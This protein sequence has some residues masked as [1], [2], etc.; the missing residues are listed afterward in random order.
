MGTVTPPPPPPAARPVAGAPPPAGGP[1]GPTT[2]SRFRLEDRPVAMGPSGTAIILTV[3]AIAV[4]AWLYFRPPSSVGEQSLQKYSGFETNIETI[5]PK[6]CSPPGCAAVYLTP[7]DGKKSGDAL[8]GAVELSNRLSDQGIECYIVFGGEP[9]PEAVKRARGL[10]HAVVFDPSGEWAKDSGIEKTPYW[11]AWR[12]GGKVRLR[13]TEPVTA[14]D[15]ISA[16][17]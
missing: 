9:I 11:I 4:A 1:P 14:A 2:T 15:L 5:V 7:A 13:S 6:D 17:R 10:H 12:T 3:V 16:I 8:A